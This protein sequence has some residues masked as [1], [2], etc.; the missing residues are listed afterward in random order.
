[1]INEIEA[2]D[3]VIMNADFTTDHPVLV[4]KLVVKKDTQF[5]VI[6]VE[7]REAAVEYFQGFVTWLPLSVLSK[8]KPVESLG[9]WRP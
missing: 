4:S 8:L 2:G 5:R 3:D 7:D 1:M 9:N 6:M